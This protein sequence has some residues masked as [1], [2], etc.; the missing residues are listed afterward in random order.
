M[1]EREPWIDV[2]RGEATLLVI[3]FHATGLM[4]YSDAPAPTSLVA[5]NDLA[6]PYWMPTLSFVSGMLADQSMDRQP[7]DYYA[8]KVR[9]ILYPFALWTAV[10]GVVFR[11]PRT[12]GSVLRLASG[13]TYLFFLPFLFAFNGG[14]YPLRRVDPVLLAGGALAATAVLPSR[15]PKVPSRFTE[16]LPYLFAMFTLGRLAGRHPQTWRRLQARVPTAL[17]ATTTFAVALAAQRGK[18]VSY[19]WEWA[20]A[21]AAAMVAFSRGAQVIEGRIPGRALGFVG[22]NSVIYYTMHF[23]VAYGAIR[24]AKKRD[25]RNGRRVFAQALVASLAIPTVFALA[26]RRSALVSRLFSA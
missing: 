21:P 6:E 4:R 8:G 13:G 25:D 19:R 14:S 5:L 20:W 17:S 26:S 10:H 24:Y 2:L 9:T 23:P 15:L 22:R 16:R 11:V 12:R 3:G 18:R 7:G 1:R